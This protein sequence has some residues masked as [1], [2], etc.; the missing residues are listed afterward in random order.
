MFYRALL[1]GFLVL[2][3]RVGQ[4]M[5]IPFFPPDHPATSTSQL[6][7]LTIRPGVTKNYR[8][9]MIPRLQVQGNPTDFGVVVPTQTA[10]VFQTIGASVF[11]EAANVSA[12]ASR[13]SGRSSY[14]GCSVGSDD[15]A[16]AEDSG[17]SSPTDVRVISEQ[18]VGAFD[19][20]VLESPDGAALIA[21]LDE[22]GYAH[23]SASNAIPDEYAKKGWVFTAMR[24]NASHLRDDIRAFD[25]EPVAMI[26]EADT[27]TYPLKLTTL[28]G[29]QEITTDLVLYIIADGRY[30]FDQGDTVWANAINVTELQNIRRSAPV[31]GSLISQHDFV[32]KIRRSVAAFET[33]EDFDL[34]RTDSVEYT[35]FG[36]NFN[37]FGASFVNEWS[38]VLLVL[39]G[40]VWRMVAEKRRLN[41]EAS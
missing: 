40:L 5:C 23:G 27:L 39:A 2:F 12:P 35:E 3:S 18:T 10:P 17:G 22:H 26:F 8:L 33:P 32:T 28:G 36:N 4:T 30:T 24:I 38:V 6:M 1:I 9:V 11:A 34:E 7:I 14:G 31:F 13:P 19:A 25:T 15:A 41:T 37:F 16:F 21:W 29:S 20:V